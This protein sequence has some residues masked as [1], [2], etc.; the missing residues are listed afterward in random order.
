MTRFDQTPG[1]LTASGR[2]AKVALVHEWFDHFYGSERVAAEILNCFPEA[3]VFTLVDIMEGDERAFLD[4]KRITTS[5]IQRL[6]FGNS[7]RFRKYLPL[8]PYAIEQFDLSDYDLVLSSSHAVAKGVL[9]GADQVHVA[10]VHT[11][12]RYAWELSHEYLRQSGL[13]RGL[14]GLLTRYFL[15]KL[16]LWDLRTVNG[17]DRFIANSAYVGRRIQKTYRRPSKVI[18]PPVDVDRFQMRPDEKKDHYLAVSRFVPYKHTETI[19]DAFVGMP[20]RKLV[21][22][23]DGP[24]LKAAK[25]R[26][27]SNITILPPQPFHELERHMREARA[28][29]FAPEEDF[30]ITPVEAQAAGTPIIAYGA[31][32]VLET[33]RDLDQSEPTGLFFEAQTPEAIRATVQRFEQQGNVINPE[34]CR[35]NAERFTASNFRRDYLDHVRDAWLDH[36]G[37]IEDVASTKVA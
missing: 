6:P 36:G 17:V 29:I 5:F 26:A 25:A 3:D 37:K 33:V 23:G 1:L 28:F 21:V 10:Y 7:K 24:G 12:M 30:G 22:I 8:F 35:K 16:R 19:V 20:D 27:T 9:T 18:H 13:A 31:G 2:P 11:P 4:G 32:G 34:H 14:K 15:H